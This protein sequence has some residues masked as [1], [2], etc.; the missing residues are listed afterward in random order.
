MIDIYSGPI[1]YLGGTPSADRDTGSQLEWDNL[2]DTL[3]PMQ[4]GQ[5]FAISTQFRITTNSVP[6][7]ITNRA[8][9]SDAVDTFNNLT[10]RDEDTVE[11]NNEQTAIDL[12]SFEGERLDDG[13][14][15]LRW[16]TAIEI[17][18]FGFRFL[19]SSSGQL[20]DAEDIGLF[21]PGQGR[22]TASGASYSITDFSAEAGQAYTYWLVDVDTAGLKTTQEDAPV[23]VPAADLSSDEGVK[24]Y[25][26]I[27]VQN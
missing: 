21:V 3:G 6:F 27:I 20:S 19:R 14:V 8:V 22:G 24:L 23:T 12:L 2:V 4:P 5:V 18:N 25:L 9:V 10:N 7:T 1:E 16:T 17:D 26:P 13:K 11:V 15:E